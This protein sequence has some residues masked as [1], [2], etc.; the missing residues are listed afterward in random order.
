M[1][2]NA[3]CNVQRVS[4][5]GVTRHRCRQSTQSSA[6]PVLLHQLPAIPEQVAV[7]VPPP[8][9]SSAVD[10]SG[11]VSVLPVPPPPCRKTRNGRCSRVVVRPITAEQ[12]ALLPPVY[13]SW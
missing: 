7:V 4:S 9:S 8:S 11:P 3:H 12:P 13:S 10:R 6:S 2:S 5:S 1:S